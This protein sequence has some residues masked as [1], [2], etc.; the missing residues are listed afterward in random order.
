[1]AKPPAAGSAAAG[2]DGPLPQSIIAQA[3]AV[4]AAN[5]P[6]QR[7]SSRATLGEASGSGLH[8]LT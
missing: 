2:Q 7:R 1:M 5:P 3:E 8:P 6:E 4:I